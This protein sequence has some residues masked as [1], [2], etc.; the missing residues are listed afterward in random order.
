MSININ[1]RKCPQNHVCPAIKA[2]K[3]GAL[4]QKGFDAP[5]VDVDKCID[6]GD[7]IDFCPTGA[8][9]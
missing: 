1:K 7:C 3:E 9:N 2:C 4:T 6:C 5:E 8:I